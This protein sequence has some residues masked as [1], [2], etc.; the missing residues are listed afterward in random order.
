MANEEYYYKNERPDG[1]GGSGSGGGNSPGG[2]SGNWGGGSGGGM[3]GGTDGNGM[4]SGQWGGGGSGGSGSGGNDDDS[5]RFPD[6]EWLYRFINSPYLKTAAG[7]K[8]VYEPVPSTATKEQLEEWG[9]RWNPETKDFSGDQKQAGWR[10]MIPLPA[11]GVMTEYS[12]GVKIDG[13]EVEVPLIVPATTDEEI[14]LLRTSPKTIPDS[15]YDR[16]RTWAEYRIGKKKSPFYNGDSEDDPLRNIYRILVSTVAAPGTIRTAGKYI[17]TGSL[18]CKVVPM[19]FFIDGDGEHKHSNCVLCVSSDESRPLKMFYFAWELAGY[20]YFNWD[21][22]GEFVIRAKWQ[23]GHYSHAEINRVRFV[24]FGVSTGWMTLPVTSGNWVDAVRVKI[25][26]DGI[27]TVNSILGK[28][29]GNQ[30]I[31][32][33]IHADS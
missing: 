23:S 7:K 3:G 24:V 16:A 20:G 29:N 27:V 5:N 12:A 8:G 13:K 14:E 11:G 1:S 32:E 30:K 26:D 22:S 4:G 17:L 15:I 10:G 18:S 31:I 21:R 6:P 19:I 25:A 9:K 28:I 33:A 2:G